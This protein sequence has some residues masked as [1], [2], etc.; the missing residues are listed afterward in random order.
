MALPTPCTSHPESSYGIP[1]GPA[2]VTY[3]GDYRHSYAA[4]TVAATVPR[5]LRELDAHF[6]FACRIR[7]NRDLAEEAR[8]R[9]AIAAD[10]L[11]HRVTFINEVQS[12]R[13]LFAISTVQVFPADSHQEKI[14]MPLVL[15]EGLSQGLA[16]VVSRKPPL[17]ELVDAG[18]AVGVPTCHPV[19][20]AV[21]VVELLREEPR[22]REL[23][24]RG[25]AVCLERFE[26]GGV[27]AAYEALYDRVLGF[28]DHAAQGAVR[29]G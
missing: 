13:E 5:I 26:V 17:S 24:E 25:R 6:I 1:H 23:A 10:G 14:D 21:A 2:L 8:I 7:D 9:T 12:L 15:L 22:R 27:A 28:E 29:A 3:A 11:S 18:A 19:A 20:L 4:R 16:T